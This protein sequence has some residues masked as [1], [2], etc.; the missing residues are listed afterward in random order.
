VARSFLHG[1]RTSDSIKHRKYFDYL[2]TYQFIEKY[3][4]PLKLY[5]PFLHGFASRLSVS[6]LRTKTP[7]CLISRDLNVS[8]GQLDWLDIPECIQIAN[9]LRKF[10]KWFHLEPRR[11]Q[12][13][14]YSWRLRTQM[15]KQ[16]DNI[17]AKQHISNLSLSFQILC[18]EICSPRK[19][20]GHMHVIIRL[21]RKRL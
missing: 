20:D 17:S 16:F 7:L 21:G 13:H 18:L 10:Y 6:L 3:V 9:V 14:W 2:R 8:R 12:I 15:N 19:I 1:N 11:L 4:A 5:T